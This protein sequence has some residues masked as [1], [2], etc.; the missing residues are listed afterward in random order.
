VRTDRRDFGTSRTSRDGLFPPLTDAD[1]E[2]LSWAAYGRRY[3]EQI[4]AHFAKAG[5]DSERGSARRKKRDTKREP[6]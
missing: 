2:T 4:A 1:R 3:A 6:V 5:S